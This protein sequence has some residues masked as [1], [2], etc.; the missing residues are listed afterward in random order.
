MRR[1][2][3]ILTAALGAALASVGTAG[4]TTFY[5]STDAAAPGTT[6][7]TPP[8]TF[9]NGSVVQYEDTTDAA[10]EFFFES[11]F[12]GGAGGENLD[13]FELLPNGHMILST[14]GQATIGALTFQN[15]DLVDYDPVSGTAM[16]IFDGGSVF[17]IPGASNVD[18]VAVLSNGNLLISTDVTQS[19]NG[20]SFFDGDVFEYDPLTGNATPYFS[21]ALFGADQNVDA[22]DVLD[23][24]RI[25][26]STALTASL[27][28]LVNF[29]NGDLVLYDPV[30]GT[31]TIW[32]PESVFASAPEDIDAVAV[33]EPN[34]LGLLALGLVGLAFV[35][36]R[37]QP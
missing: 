33:P 8:V 12:N 28:G 7:G 6:M 14:A 21:E 13:A 3:A 19:V 16:V 36:A 25:A 35:G 30:A 20:S 22:F 29:D 1:R 4:A 18:A 23:D 10:T 26:L 2:L 32:L 15:D 34:T 11:V 31:A 17:E 24:G 9:P 5:L 37:R 27:G